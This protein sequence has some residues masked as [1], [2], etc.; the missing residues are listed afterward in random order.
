MKKRAVVAMSGGVDS[1]TAAYLLLKKGYDVIGISLKLFN[2]QDSKEPTQ[3]RK[4]CCGIQ[5][6]NDA[7][8]VALKLGIPFYALNYVEEFKAGVIDY[9]LNEYKNART[10]NP[11][12][13]CNEII[14]F[15]SLLKKAKSLG[16]DFIA[17]GHYAK[18]GYDK[19]VK[20]YILKKAKDIRKDQSYFLFSL[21]QESL[22]HTIFPLADFTKH[23][24]RRV[25]K[26]IG[27]KVY[28]KPASHEICFIPDNNYRDFLI[29]NDPAIANPGPIIDR[30]GKV[31]SSHKGIGFYTVG[32]RRGLG[33]WGKHPLYVIALDGKRNTVIVGEKKDLYSKRLIA[34]RVN[35]IAISGLDK[36]LKVKAQVRYNQPPSW[37]VVSKIDKD[38]VAV[39]FLRHEEAVT[40]GQAVVFY[41]NNV[42]LGGGI[43]ENGA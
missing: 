7:R 22:K 3:G 8:A 31:L 25:A 37:A 27:I 21:P 36:P 12:V 16:A 34:K 24:V 26:K 41:H 43:I 17:T 14:K 30:Q 9:F 29:K 28:N 5:G 38:K 23:Q 2:S 15:D 6:I 35:W 18:V 33:I 42:V 1:S 13:M 10:P 4:A 11:C 39:D 19:K 32:Q 20:R 40:P